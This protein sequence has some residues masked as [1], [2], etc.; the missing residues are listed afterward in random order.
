LGL[1]W[2][3]KQQP[4]TK[5]NSGARFGRQTLKKEP[6]KGN[7]PKLPHL[8]KKGARPDKETQRT[9]ALGGRGE[10]RKKKWALYLDRVGRGGRVFGGTKLR[11]GEGKT[12][13]VHDWITT[14]KKKVWGGWWVLWQFQKGKQRTVYSLKER[15]K[16]TKGFF[17]KILTKRG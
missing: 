9:T 5:K 17:L 6:K 4:K 7:F 2:K 8:I 14:G 16:L 12:I 3:K 1:T 13:G 11:G 15:K 10:E